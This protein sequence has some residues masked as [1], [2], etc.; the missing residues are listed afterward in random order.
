MTRHKN[1]KPELRDRS[2]QGRRKQLRRKML[3][4]ATIEAHPL[5]WRWDHGVLYDKH[6]AEIIRESPSACGKAGNLAPKPY[7]REVIP[8]FKG[9]PSDDY[10]PLHYPFRHRS[11]G[12]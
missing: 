7:E 2:A 12:F 4:P 11:Y 8:P 10:N 3:K 1:N 5:P 6:G 9:D